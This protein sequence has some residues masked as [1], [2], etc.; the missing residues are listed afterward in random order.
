MINLFPIPVLDGGHL[1]FFTV[2]AVV[3]QTDPKIINFLMTIGLFLLIGL[4]IF[5]IFNDFALKNFYE[6]LLTLYL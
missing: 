1:L 6:R 5:S 3:G 4:M 2:E